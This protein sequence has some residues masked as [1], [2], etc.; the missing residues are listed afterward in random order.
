MSVSNWYFQDFVFRY[1]KK[2]DLS[3][4]YF[5]Q[6]TELTERDNFD[7]ISLNYKAM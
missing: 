1:V 3:K 6:T 7:C 5:L 2:K 4:N